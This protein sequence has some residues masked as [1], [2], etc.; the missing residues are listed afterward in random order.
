MKG[1]R[2]ELE[3]V[4]IRGRLA[5]RIVAELDDHLACDPEANLG[6]PRLIAERFAA[7]LCLPKTRRA[8]YLGFAGLVAAAALLLAVLAGRSGG[9]PVAGIVAI[10]AGQV[11]FAAGVLALWGARRGTAPALVQRRVLVALL[12]GVVVL[13]AVVVSVAQWIAI[14]ALVPALLLAASFAELRVAVGITPER[15]AS[16]RGFAPREAAWLGIAVSAFVLLA[17]AR[18]ERSWLEGV[19]RGAAEAVAFVAGYLVLGRRLGIRR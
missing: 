15:I 13:V 11:A 4:G 9:G 16:S 10:L 17:S 3:R 19:E 1:L 6:E 12:A 5:D 2:A 8:T 14:L 18:A 7:E